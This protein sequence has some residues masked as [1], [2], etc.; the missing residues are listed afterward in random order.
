M[1]CEITD[2]SNEM[3]FTNY[4]FLNE[5]M[6]RFMRQWYYC[7]HLIKSYFTCA[8]QLSSGAVKEKGEKCYR[9]ILGFDGAMSMK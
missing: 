6:G 3:H 2:D 5:L 8:C 1:L 4:L 7:F 9:P